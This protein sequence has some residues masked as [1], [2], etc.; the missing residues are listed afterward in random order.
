MCNPHRPHTWGANHCE[1]A[2]GRRYTRGAVLWN[3]RG[4]CAV[5]RARAH[6]LSVHRCN[7]LSRAA[8]L[9][10]AGPGH[11]A[12]FTWARTAWATA[13]VYAEAAACR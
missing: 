11:A 3:T 8:E 6:T 4:R 9:R 2:G 5:T 10:A 1:R 12:G 7:S 13:E